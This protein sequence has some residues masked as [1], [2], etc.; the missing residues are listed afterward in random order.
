MRCVKRRLAN[1]P[2]GV[3]FADDRRHGAQISDKIAA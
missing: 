2:W 1:H 3:I